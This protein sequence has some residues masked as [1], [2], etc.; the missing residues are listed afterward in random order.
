[1][2]FIVIEWLFYSYNEIMVPR[3]DYRA[4]LCWSLIRLGWMS[5]MFCIVIAHSLMVE[6]DADDSLIFIVGDFDSVWLEVNGFIASVLLG[7][8][9]LVCLCCCCFQESDGWGG[10]GGSPRSRSPNPNSDDFAFERFVLPQSRIDLGVIN[11]F[12]QGMG[13]AMCSVTIFVVGFIICGVVPFFEFVSKGLSGGTHF[14]YIVSIWFLAITAMTFQTC[15]FVRAK[16]CG[17]DEDRAKEARHKQK[18]RDI[19]RARS[20]PNLSATR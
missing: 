7:L 14:P 18:V 20:A 5:F 17:D 16:C 2:V 15:W 13:T 10:L 6:S 19:K 9:V 1:M 8:S 11:E 3:T 4:Y 12:E